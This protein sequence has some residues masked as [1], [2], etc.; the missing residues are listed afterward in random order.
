MFSEIYLEIRSAIKCMKTILEIGKKGL[1]NKGVL[2]FITRY[3]TYF[4]QF[5][6]SLIIASK[7]DPDHFGVWGFMLLLINYFNITNFGIPNSASVLL[8]HERHNRANFGSIVSNSMVAVLGLSGLIFLTG[9][10]YWYFGE[11]TFSKYDIGSGY[12]VVC[13]IAI[14]SHVNVLLMTISRVGNKIFE[15]A[16]YQSIIPVL[17]LVSSLVFTG[18][19]LLTGLVGSYLIG[20]VV[21]LVFF[22][23]RGV[24]PKLGKVNGKWLGTLARKGIFLFVYN[25]CFYLIVLSLRSIIGY[26]YSVSDF[27][28]FSFAFTIANSVLL[29]F[30]AMAFLLFPKMIDKL[31]DKVNPNTFK[32]VVD[33]NDKFITFAFT[34]TFLV[35]IVYPVVPELFPKYHGLASTLVLLG[36]TLV[37]FINSMGYSTYLM[38]NGMERTLAVISFAGLFTNVLCA[39]ILIKVLHVDFQYVAIATMMAYAVFTSLTVYFGRKRMGKN[40]S[41]FKAFL[42]GFPLRLQVPIYISILIISLDGTLFMF[43][44]ALVFV[45]LNI[46][47]IKRFAHTAKGLFAKPDFMNV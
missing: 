25:L 46:Q 10:L 14:L 35:L 37:L 15:L 3:F 47:S 13:G 1:L 17:V 40:V 19:D 23:S 45:V 4:L 18:D 29:T 42:E 34:L 27:G 41:L 9:L 44:P 2:Y 43:L 39:L 6:S 38:S 32:T 36:L 24:L 33:I 16:F 5:V 12:Y 20:N 8:V 11:T 7:L 21:A 28:V 30:K 31:N 22:L 26:F